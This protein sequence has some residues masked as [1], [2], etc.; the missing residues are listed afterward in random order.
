MSILSIKEILEDDSIISSYK[1]SEKTREMVKEQIRTIY[2]AKEV[3]HYD[4]YK[5]FTFAKWISLGYRP[6][7]GSKALQT[8]AYIE[9]KDDKGEVIETYPKKINLF[10]YKSV[11]PLTD[12]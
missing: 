3:K 9:K 8:I 7:K 2:G 6:K 11:E 1:G 10:Y 12:K 5:T 4:P